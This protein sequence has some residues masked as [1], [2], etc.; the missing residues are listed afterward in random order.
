MVILLYSRGLKE[1]KHSPKSH[2]SMYFWAG[3]SET[4]PTGLF[5]LNPKPKVWGLELRY[6][7]EGFGVE[8]NLL[9]VKGLGLRFYGLG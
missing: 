6:L 4:K 2:G 1:P 8:V 9:R 3:N 5:F 7:D